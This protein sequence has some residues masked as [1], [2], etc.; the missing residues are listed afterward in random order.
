MSNK[1]KIDEK[2]PSQETLL[3]DYAQRLDRHRAGRCAVHVHL[4]KL[5][6]Y[7]RRDQH[8]RIAANTFENLVGTYE[9]QIFILSNADLVFVGKGASFA[10]IDGAVIKLRYLFSEDPLSQAENDSRDPFCTWYNI[11]TQYPEFFALAQQMAATAERRGTGGPLTATQAQQQPSDP[12][13]PDQL[14]RIEQTL[15]RA[16][17]T[18]LMRRQSAC[19]LIDGAPPQTVFQELFVSI[20]DLQKLIAPKISLLSNRW[21]FQHLTETLDKRMLALLPRHNDSTIQTRFSLNLNVATLLSPEFLAFDGELR[22]TARGTVVIELQVFDVFADVG[23]FF[24]ARDFVRERGYRLCLD[25]VSHI[26]APTIDRE[27]LGIDLVKI[28]WDPG[29]SDA[30]SDRRNAEFRETIKRI[31]EARVILARCGSASAVEFGHSA[32]IAVFQGWHVDS[33]L[34]PGK[35]PG[36]VSLKPTAARA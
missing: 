29:M 32:G 34:N 6:A 15:V 14:A 33:L 36:V 1:H 30:A 31:G 28:M 3:L 10:D 11:E 2:L 21:L 12:L 20:A 23:S 17:L 26:A 9:G 18:N 13:T 4:S 8:I 16:D 19:A 22:A 27:R 24:F 35:K 7:N 25:G 5:R